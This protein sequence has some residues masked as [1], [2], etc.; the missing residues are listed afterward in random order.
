MSIKPIIFISYS[1]KDEPR[2][3]GPVEEKWLSYVQSFLQPAMK[4][5]K[6]DLWTDE[7]IPGGAEWEKHIKEK[8]AGCDICILLVSRHSLNSQYCIDIEVE[9]IRRRQENSESVKTY[10]IYLTHAP[11][12]ALQPIIRARQRVAHQPTGQRLSWC[13]GS[14][15]LVVLQPG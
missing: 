12:V 2:N 15:R 8:L 11:K 3:P 6:F 10:P 4:N 5:G 1:H 13:R 7:D 14:A 9:T